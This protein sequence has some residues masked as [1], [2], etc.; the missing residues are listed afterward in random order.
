[1]RALVATVEKIDST[2]S[3]HVLNSLGTLGQGHHEELREHKQFLQ[4][5]NKLPAYVLKMSSY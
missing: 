3:I 5:I 4:G 1:M 2:Q